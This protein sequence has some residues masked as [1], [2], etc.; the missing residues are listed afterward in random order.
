MVGMA[1]ETMVPSSDARKMLSIMVAVI[2]YSLR[3]LMGRQST[4]PQPFRQ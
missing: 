2:T 4:P 1:V 3:S